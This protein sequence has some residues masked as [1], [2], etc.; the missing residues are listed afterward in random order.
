VY[1]CLIAKT[2]TVSS[3]VVAEGPILAELQPFHEPQKPIRIVADRVTKT[4]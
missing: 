2:S 1:V 3:R 4:F